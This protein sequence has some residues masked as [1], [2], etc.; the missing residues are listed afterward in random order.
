MHSLFP[1]FMNGCRSIGSFYYVDVDELT[2]STL[3]G[4]RAAN[5]EILEQLK[6]IQDQID[7]GSFA[8]K[9]STKKTIAEKINE[10][11]QD[12]QGAGGVIAPNTGQKAGNFGFYLMI[13]GYIAY[14]TWSQ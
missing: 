11:A 5:L 9:S 10:S 14:Y 1:A 8:G 3:E 6:L 7:N 2:R 12:Q 4:L 13:I